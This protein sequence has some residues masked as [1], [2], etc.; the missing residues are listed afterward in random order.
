MEKGER[1]R[2][3]RKRK[4]EGK[5]KGT[6]RMGRI[7]KGNGIGEKVNEGIIEGGERR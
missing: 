6:E 5:Q 7:C 2:K 4:I 1:R 3:Y